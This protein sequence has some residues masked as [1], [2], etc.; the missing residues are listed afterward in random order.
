MRAILLR[1]PPSPF[2]HGTL[3]PLLL[4]LSLSLSH[5]RFFGPTTPVPLYESRDPR[6]KRARRRRCCVHVHLC[7]YV[8]IRVRASSYVRAASVCVSGA[9]AHA[10]VAA[11]LC[12]RA[13]ACVCTRRCARER[14]TPDYNASRTSDC[15]NIKRRSRGR[16]KA[17]ATPKIVP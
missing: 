5:R 17:R 11:A 16:G 2:F 7:A 12:G 13:R 14:F 4:S 8:R 9:S 3:P 10:R 15:C 1:V 6:G